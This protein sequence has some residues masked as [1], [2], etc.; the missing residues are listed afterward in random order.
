MN[1]AIWTRVS[2]D[3]QETANQLDALRQW[4][5]NR[6]LEVVREFEVHES[7]F[8]GKHRGELKEVLQ[9]AHV[10]EFNVLLVW[11]LDRLS[12]EGSEQTLALVRQ[13]DERGCEV[14]SMQEP[15]MNGDRHTR[16][17]LMAIAGWVAGMESKRRGERIKAGLERRRKQGLPVGRRSG[18]KDRKR[19]KTSGYF[20][21]EARK[22]EMA[23]V[24]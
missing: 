16:E 1:A 11:A 3:E 15:W 17:L 21:R 6:G 23:R 9:A 19:R 13:F 12:R 2:T 18:A 20:A 24:A 5:R 14:W 22:R 8:T 10:G 4:A 7:A